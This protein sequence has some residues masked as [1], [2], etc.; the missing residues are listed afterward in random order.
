MLELGPALAYFQRAQEP[1]P[2]QQ[3]PQVLAWLREQVVLELGL[4]CFQALERVRQAQ[5]KPGLELVLHRGLERAQDLE[6][7]QRTQAEPGP[8]LL[9]GP[10]PE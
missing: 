2:E 9:Q 7:A 8:V 6:R 10:G 1:E 4:A 3:E 5:M